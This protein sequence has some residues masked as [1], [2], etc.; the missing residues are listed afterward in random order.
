MHCLLARGGLQAG[1]SEDSCW[2]ARARALGARR[3]PESAGR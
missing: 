2:P 3:R 1:L